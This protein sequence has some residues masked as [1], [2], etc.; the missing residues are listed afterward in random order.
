VSMPFPRSL[1]DVSQLAELYRPPHQVVLD[2]AIDH[3]DDGC[4]GFIAAATFVVVGAGGADGRFDVSPRGGPAGFVKVLD[5][6]RLAIPDLN[7]NNRLDTLRNII[8]R[9]YAGLLFVIPGRG[10]TLRVNGRAF[11][12]TAD[13]ILDR[14]VDE[15]R[16]PTTAIGV[17]VQ[18][19]FVH[20]AKA[21]R[22]GGLWEPERWP[23]AD[24]APSA[25]AMF[26]GHLG[27]QDVSVEAIEADLEAGYVAGLAADRPEP[28]VGP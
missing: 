17:E 24:A 23:A 6:S 27:L 4:R 9:P 15:L 28:A 25:A 7:G 14:F 13:D 1:T 2:K 26:R 10:E 16:R 20:C 21:F 11:V 8:E 12:T 3:L 19:A 18:S 22:R 5:G